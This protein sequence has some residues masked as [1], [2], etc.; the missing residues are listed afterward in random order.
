LIPLVLGRKRSYRLK[1]D[2]TVT[3]RNGY[4][5]LI[6]EIQFGKRK[7]MKAYEEKGYFRMNYLKGLFENYW[8][9]H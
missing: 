3:E 4:I 1:D 9:T 6:Y 7:V 5:N 8:Q 2:I